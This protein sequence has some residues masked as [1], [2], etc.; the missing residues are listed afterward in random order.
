MTNPHLVV[1][2]PMAVGKSTV[3]EALAGRTGRPLRD[4]DRDL[5]E[6]EGLTGRQFA[7]AKGVEAL[8]R[9]EAEHLHVRC[10]RRCR[11]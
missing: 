2:G 6:A 4:S 11:R 5:A 7:R 3:G 10:G 8:H 9:W 1:M